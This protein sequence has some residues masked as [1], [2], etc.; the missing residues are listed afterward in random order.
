MSA[1]ARTAR[2][3]LTSHDDRYRHAR[4]VVVVILTLAALL[5]PAT[6]G[7]LGALA[8][9]APIPA[10]SHV[11]VIRD[12]ALRVSERLVLPP[13]ESEDSAG[14]CYWDAATRGNGIGRSFWID[15]AGVVHAVGAGVAPVS[16]SETG[17]VSMERGQ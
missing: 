16:Q 7:L 1:T 10:G 3:F 17:P 5:I 11:V 4:G 15:G 14:P 8:D 2:R 6:L 9:A 13:C 12:D